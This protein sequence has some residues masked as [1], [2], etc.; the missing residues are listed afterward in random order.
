[1][2]ARLNLGCGYNWKE[3]YPKYDGLDIIDYGQKY[4]GDIND[5]ITTIESKTYDEIMAN[6]FLEH[7]D[8]DAVKV[9]ITNINRI[10][11]SGGE[12]KFVVPHK[13]KD[14]AWVLTHKTFWN[15]TSVR[16]LAQP[17]ADQV[18]GF[19]KW[20]IVDVVVNKRGDIHAWLKNAS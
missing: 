9:I 5:L 13:K 19:G 12:F 14:A 6:H 1:M 20:E 18:Y 2:V 8:Q 10:L 11:K 16:W 4:I 15:T 3:L 17:E 7:F